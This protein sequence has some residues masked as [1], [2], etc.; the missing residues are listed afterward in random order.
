MTGVGAIAAGVAFESWRPYLLGM[1]GLLLAGGFLFAWRDHKKACAAG[2]LCATKPISRWNRIALGILA[3]GVVA[4]ATFP[5]YSGAVAQMV[6]RQP[7]PARFVTSVALSMVA[8]RV[9][10]MDCPACAVSLSAALR[11]LPGVADAKLDVESR[12]AV[13]TYDP[14]TQNVAALEKVISDAGFHIATSPHSL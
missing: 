8:F 4:L 10:D 3:T 6:V 13:I 14:G 12:K 7:G 2:S 5:Y 1:T 11:K 9:P